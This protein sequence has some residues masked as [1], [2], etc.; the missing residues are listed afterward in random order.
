VILCRAPCVHDSR[1]LREADTLSRIGYDPLILGVVSEE[2]R[3]RRGMEGGFPI[4][5]LA[6]SSPFSW[7]KR[8]VSRGGAAGTPQAQPGSAHV[9]GRAMSFAIRVHRWLRTLDFY[10]RAIRVVRRTQPALIHC[11][12][13]N[14]MW[15]GVAA[16]LTTRATVVYDAHELWA[17]R[18]QR[19]EPR[20]WLLACEAL[21]VRVAH[22][23]LAASPGYSE[24]MSRRYRT[25]PPRVIR[26]IPES[27]H[28][29]ESPA[30]NGDP[31][32]VYVGALTTGRGLEISIRAL[33]HVSQVRLRL[34][35][36]GQAHYRAELADLARTEG[37]VDRVEFTGAV[38]P[39]QVLTEIGGASVGL[40]LIQPV[41]LSYRM[42][43]P[44][45]LFEYVAAGLPVLG[46][47]LPAIGGLI[48]DYGIGL[49]AKPADPA[50]VAAKLGEMVRPERNEAFRTATR[51]AAG[52]LRWENESQLLAEAYATAA[53]A[54]G[55]WQPR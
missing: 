55:R 38:S 7:V 1:I 25:R 13:Y 39:E 26:N 34:V 4:I 47:D 35:G 2:V 14:T 30:P 45:K 12:D 46:S 32:A 9:D 37:V 6:P 29:P 17:D 43:L 42:S 48:T 21:F 23:T 49:L 22:Q 52:E 44:N 16:R 20:W 36:P 41:C 18:N 24:V 31:T 27:D 5:R 33:A 19:P 8:R 3:E 54:A 51:R 50:D 40:A 53:E 28:L 10:R 15:V 11:N